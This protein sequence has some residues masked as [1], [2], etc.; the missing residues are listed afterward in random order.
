MRKRTTL[1]GAVFGPGWLIQAEP[2]QTIAKLVTTRYS[3][4]GNYNYWFYNYKHIYI[5]SI[6]VVP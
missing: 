1:A 6:V 2:P 5:Y 4:D 3:V